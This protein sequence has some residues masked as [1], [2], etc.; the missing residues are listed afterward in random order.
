MTG[1]LDRRSAPTRASRRALVGWPLV[2]LLTVAHATTDLLSAGLSALLPTVQVRFGLGETALAGLVATSWVS[3][4]LTQPLFGALSDRLGA[5]RVAAAGV[6]LAAVLLSLLAVAPSTPLLFAVLL[7]GGLGS[8][9]YH[10]PATSLARMAGG[11]RS[12]LAVSL[13]S[14]G[15]TLGLALGPL[16][17]LAVVGTY[18]AGAAP[19]LMVPGLALTLACPPT[20]PGR[21]PA[22]RCWTAASSPGRSGC[23]RWPARCRASPTS[24]SPLGCRCGWSTPACRPTRR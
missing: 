21:R 23:W 4:S 18:G 11:R 9:A 3:T 16:V 1:V 5:R 8:A 13:F 14:A 17:L 24:A 20:S 7:V 6:G 22:R 10:P 19:W 12:E 2:A 15:G